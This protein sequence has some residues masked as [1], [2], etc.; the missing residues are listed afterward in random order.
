MVLHLLYLVRLL[1]VSTLRLDLCP[2]HTDLYKKDWKTVIFNR[3]D[4]AKNVRWVWKKK[5]VSNTWYLIPNEVQC[6]SFIIC[7][8]FSC[9]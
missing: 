9:S 4:I 6:S 2:L 8:I 5:A 3:K 1:M 7:C